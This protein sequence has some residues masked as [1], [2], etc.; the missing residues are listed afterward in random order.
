MICFFL[1]TSFPWTYTKYD[2]TKKMI[3]KCDHF[4]KKKIVQHFITAHLLSKTYFWEVVFKMRS[5]GQMLMA[6][7]IFRSYRKLIAG[8]LGIF[9]G[10]LGPSPTCAK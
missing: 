5:E 8:D 10:H 4:A 2:C 7:F 9:L 6:R 3:T 1:Q